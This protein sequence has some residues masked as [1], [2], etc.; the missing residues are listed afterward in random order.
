MRA[1]AH[2]SEGKKTNKSAAKQNCV[3]EQHEVDR[4]SVVMRM[5]LVRCAECV[6]ALFIWVARGLFELDFV[7]AAQIG[8]SLWKM[9]WRCID[10]L[11]GFE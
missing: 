3:Q 4:M 7:A 6:I 8:L 2:T 10:E 9:D 11:I 1:Q 5:K